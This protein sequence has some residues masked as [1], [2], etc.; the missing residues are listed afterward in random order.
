M[1]GSFE[2]DQHLPARPVTYSICS[3]VGNLAEYAL[4]LDSCRKAGFDAG[5]SEF[6]YVD[7]SQGNKYDAYAG[8][9]K[10]VAKASG[11]YILLV[12]QDVEFI[13]DAEPVL[14]QRL[15]EMDRLDPRWAVLG[16]AGGA[17]VKREYHRLSY[18]HGSVNRGPFPQ[19]VSSLD[20]NFLLLKKSAG[21][22]FS[23]DLQG[24][25]LYGTDLCLQ[26][27][28]KGFSC[29]VIDFHL[30]HKSTG[31]I[32]ESFYQA[33]EAFMRR[34][35]PHLR[36]RYIR[37]TCTTMFISS[38]PLLNEVMNKAWMVS[39]AKFVKKIELKLKGIKY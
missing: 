8:L 20:E 18:P 2:I 14:R 35:A 27:E 16:N 10:L 34:Y 1:T 3:L 9:N 26:A 23:P 37:T 31:N 33:R 11:T 15:A 39:L 4:L 32:N 12:H 7:N 36:P 17:D 5:N 29:Y 22:G 13:F 30:L 38:S 24:F 21:L 6:L 19:K 25:H 28:Q